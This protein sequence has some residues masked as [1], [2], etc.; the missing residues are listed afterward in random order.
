LNLNVPIKP[1]LELEYGGQFG[2][3]YRANEKIVR[4][5]HLFGFMFG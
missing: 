5:N 3:H 2:S 4:V 1:K